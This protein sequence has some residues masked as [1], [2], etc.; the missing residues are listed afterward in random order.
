MA[1]H[2]VAPGLAFAMVILGLIA[3]AP[4]RALPASEAVVSITQGTLRPQVI[5][6]TP[7]TPVTWINVSGTPVARLVFDAGAG[8]PEATGLFTSS[9]TVSFARPGVYRYTAYVGG[10]AWPIRG[11]VVVK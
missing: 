8:A 7:G 6:V 9:V 3:L 11:Q 4:D 2:T 5:I 1:N 10:R